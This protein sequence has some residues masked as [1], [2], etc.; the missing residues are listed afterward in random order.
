MV[1]L[2]SHISMID[3]TDPGTRRFV[4]TQF[5]LARRRRRIHTPYGDR[6]AT[7]LLIAASFS[8][9]R[10]DSTPIMD[11]AGEMLVPAMDTAI[12]PKPRHWHMRGH[13]EFRTAH[14]DTNLI[15]TLAPVME[16]FRRG[17]CRQ[18]AECNECDKN[19]PHRKSSFYFE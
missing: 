15:R 9:S 13:A 4:T 2:L 19:L 1:A 17:S 7:T 6:N 16:R 3:P 5:A 18:S 11:A 12:T 8:T 10:T 14:A